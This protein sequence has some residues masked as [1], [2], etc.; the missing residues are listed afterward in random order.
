MCSGGVARE[1]DAAM[2]GWWRGVGSFEIWAIMW[3]KTVL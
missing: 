3:S 1:I 2:K